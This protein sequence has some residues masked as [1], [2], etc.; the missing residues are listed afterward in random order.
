MRTTISRHIVCFRSRR[1]LRCK[2]VFY[3]FLTDAFGATWGLLQRGG[4]LFGHCGSLLPRRGPI[5]GNCDIDQNKKVG[6]ST[7][8]GLPRFYYGGQFLAIGHKDHGS[9]VHAIPQACRCR[10]I[11]E[12]MAEVRTT[13]A[14]D[15][16]GTNH[17]MAPV[18][19]FFDGLFIYGLVKTRPPS[20]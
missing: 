4:C 11:V 14:I 10:A 1:L 9:G 18:G 12:H 15:Y 5:N 7:V 8:F 2:S 17:A 16:L 13:P 19:N 3:V 20:A 6:L